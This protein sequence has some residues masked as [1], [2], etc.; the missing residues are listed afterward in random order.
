MSP[1][2]SFDGLR[3]RVSCSVDRSLTIGLVGYYGRGNFGDDLV[4]A[5]I[6]THLRRQGHRCLVLSGA[7]DP[8]RLVDEADA[9]VVGG[10]SLLSRM[11]HAWMSRSLRRHL[12]PAWQAI[13]TTCAHCGR[14]GTPLFVISV[15]GDGAAFDEL[16]PG[17]VTLLRASAAATVRHP[18]AAALYERAGREAACYPDIVLQAC[19]YFPVALPDDDG[20]RS[21]RRLSIG[22]DVYWSNL[23]ARGAL[24]APLLLRQLVRDRS[25][26]SF[27]YIDSTHRGHAPFRAIE[28]PRGAPNAER[29]QFHDVR[30]DLERLASLDL[31]LSTRLHVGVAA[32]SYGVPFVSFFGEPK[33]ALFLRDVGLDRRAVGHAAALTLCRRGG[34]QAALEEWLREGVFASVSKA[35][36]RSGGHLAALDA[37][38][39]EI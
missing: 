1:S 14:T 5:I 36:D 9:I 2:S 39:Q 20:R 26:R 31:V 25:D 37:M 32:M 18:E 16:A 15:G 24:H 21:A 23:M 17:Q 38:L 27:I 7:D 13:D 8:V 12:E 28:P 3:T 6:G 33:T 35:I 22:I 11:P 10:G 30:A 4:A 34:W 29:Y 19:R